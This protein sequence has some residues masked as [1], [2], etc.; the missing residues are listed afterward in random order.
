LKALTALRRHNELLSMLADTRA[1]IYD[2]HDP[3][4][5]TGDTFKQLDKSKQAAL[6]EILATID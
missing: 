4:D 5:E 2:S 6:R 3:L 1:R